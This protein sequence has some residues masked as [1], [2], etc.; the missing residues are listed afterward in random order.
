MNHT[1][2]VEFQGV[3]S[4]SVGISVGVPQGSILGLLL[5][6]LHID[7]LSGMTSECSI[8][9]YADDTVLF[10]SSPQASLIANKL[11]TKLC[12]I[13]C[14]LFDNSLF[15]NVTK[16]EAMLFG[17]AQRISNADSFDIHIDGKKIKQQVSEFTY[18]GVVFDEC[19]SFNG[20]VKKLISK[21]GKRVG[22]VGCLRD[23]LTLHSANVVYTTLIRP[24]LDYCDTVWGCCGEGNAQAL[25]ALPN[26]AA[27]IIARTDRSSPAM[28]ILK[29]LSLADRRRNNVFKL[30]KKCIR[31]RCPQYFKDYFKC[32]GSVH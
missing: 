10:C 13:E 8:L 27:R 12:K 11:N 6:L 26:R 22:I 7:D 14:W 25:Q 21:A 19:L 9:M 16:T 30:V 23:N 5:F 18:L 32:N 15:V 4:C 1:Q 29:W 17:T 31:G 2:S 24:I 3:T 20:H 28:D